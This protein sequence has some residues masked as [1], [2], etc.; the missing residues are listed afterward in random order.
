VPGRLSSNRAGTSGLKPGVAAAS[1]P[2]ET[3][4]K[5][6][7]R[8]DQR[9][10]MRIWVKPRGKG[11][12]KRNVVGRAVLRSSSRMRV[13]SQN[14]S[15]RD[16]PLH[17][18]PELVERD[19]NPYGWGGAKT[20]PARRPTWEAMH[21]REHRAASAFLQSLPGPKRAL[22]REF[23]LWLAAGTAAEAKSAIPLQKRKR[24]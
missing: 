21:P 2:A 17:V 11:V 8:K 18:S 9:T 1:E 20:S 10:G 23:R 16:L 12:S 19:F 24:R 4:Q 15:L 5:S 22:H 13:S 14:N 7:A 3:L 6:N